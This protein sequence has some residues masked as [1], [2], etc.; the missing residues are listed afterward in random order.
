ME[1]KTNETVSNNCHQCGGQSKPSKGFRNIH[2][3][4]TTDL[5]REFETKLLDCIK[6]ESCGHS[7]IPETSTNET[8]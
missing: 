4:Q 5:S 7:W 6:C 3:I 1:Q 2:N 8:S